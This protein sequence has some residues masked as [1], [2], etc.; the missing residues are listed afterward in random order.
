M[1][2]RAAG[3]RQSILNELVLHSPIAVA[4]FR[5]AVPVA[6]GATARRRPSPAPTYN[7][8]DAW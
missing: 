4:A 7:F 1:E 3:F 5:P 6:G 2:A 8:P